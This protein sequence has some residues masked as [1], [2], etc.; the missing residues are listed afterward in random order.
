MPEDYRGSIPLVVGMEDEGE[1]IRMDRSGR[2]RVESL[3]YEPESRQ[4]GLPAA[5]LTGPSS[6]FESRLREAARAHVE[7]RREPPG[8]PQRKSPPEWLTKYMEDEGL[9][10]DRRFQ[11]AFDTGGPD[12]ATRDAL[13]REQFRWRDGG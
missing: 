5:S 4:E 2:G 12:V 1:T 6:P 11:S 10:E 9:I 13:E 3:S 7:Q 8:P